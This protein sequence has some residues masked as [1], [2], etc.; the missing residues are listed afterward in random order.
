[1]V[2]ARVTPIAGGGGGNV[3][4]RCVARVGVRRSFT[5]NERRY[6]EEA[7]GVTPRDTNLMELDISSHRNLENGGVRVQPS[8][9]RGRGE[10]RYTYLRSGDINKC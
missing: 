5:R 9:S 1:M 8:L 10:A 7:T 2:P 4:E 3:G 6:R